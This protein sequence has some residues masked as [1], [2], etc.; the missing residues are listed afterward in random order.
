MTK[1]GDFKL[2]K[3]QTCILRVNLHC[4]GCKQKVKKILQRIEGVF[5]VSIDAEQQKVTVS[6]SVDADTLIKR[7]VKSGKHAELWSQK[8]NQNQKQKNNFIK[9]EKKNKGQKQQALPKGLESFKPQQKFCLF[10]PEED[11]DCLDDDE[12]DEDEEDDLF[13]RE[14]A[15]QLN[16]LRQH[17]FNSANKKGAIPVAAVNNGKMNSGENGSGG[18]KANANQNMGI[19][20]SPCGID[21][22]TMAALRMNNAHP[23]GV[24]FN[25]MDGKTGNDINTI[26]GMANLH[27]GNAGNVAAALGIQQP[28]SASNGFLGSGSTG[29]PNPAF[30]TGHHLPSS[31]MMNM[32]GSNHLSPSPSMMMNVNM[33]NRHAMAMQP[34]QMMYHRSPLVPP[35]TGYYYNCNYSPPSCTYAEAPNYHSN[36]HHSAAHMFSDENTNGCSI[37]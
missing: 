9:D 21:Q 36:D 2:L 28:T 31:M 32:N 7:L 33:Q 17:A 27:G 8:P 11:D 24:N 35:Y 34:P 14:K 5:T 37:M 30:A 10:N 3:I 25:S 29:L 19:K 26:M 6:G 18:K 1:D 15:N 4:D 12:E 23:G 16:L 22:K 20:P 13:L